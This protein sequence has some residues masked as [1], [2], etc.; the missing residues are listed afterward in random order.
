MEVVGE[1]GDGNWVD[2]ELWRLDFDTSAKVS[3]IAKEL[4]IDGIV[5]VFP[6]M[7]IIG[8]SLGHQILFNVFMA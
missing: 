6:S 3:C 1:Q 5:L 7:R 2:L 4:I 8:I